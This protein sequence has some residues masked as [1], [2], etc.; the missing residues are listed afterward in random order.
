MHPLRGASSEAVVTT[1]CMRYT[2]LFTLE[3]HMFVLMHWF[4]CYYQACAHVTLHRAHK[5]N[6]SCRRVIGQLRTEY[7]FALSREVAA[8]QAHNALHAA[9]NTTTAGIV[10]C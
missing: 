2:Q 3:L 6:K 7:L 10:L 5:R 4:Y 9:V 1:K 8:Q